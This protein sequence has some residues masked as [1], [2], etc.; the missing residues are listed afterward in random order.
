MLWNNSQV[1]HHV[2]L[3]ISHLL[4]NGRADD[5]DFRFRVAE[6]AGE[7]GKGEGF[8]TFHDLEVVPGADFF[9]FWKWTDVLVEELE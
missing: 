1:E 4:P 2:Q 3:R 9:L 7:E 6:L 8:E 5:V